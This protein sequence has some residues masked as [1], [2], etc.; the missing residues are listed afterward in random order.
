VDETFWEPAAARTLH[1]YRADAHA[2]L[3]KEVDG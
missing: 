2:W 1:W 3:T